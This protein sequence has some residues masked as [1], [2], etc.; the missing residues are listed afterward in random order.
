MHPWED[1]AETWAH[2]IH[3]VDTLETASDSGLAILGNTIVSPLPLIAERPFAATLSEWLPLTVCLNQ[4]TRSMGVRDAYPFALTDRVIE[5]LEF[6][7]G[8]CLG[9]K[10]DGAAHGHSTGPN[11]GAAQLH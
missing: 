9:A 5:K 2:Y 8:I 6:V 3:I 4:L 10:R 7:H 1:F 11:A